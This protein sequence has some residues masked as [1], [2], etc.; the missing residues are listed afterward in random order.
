MAHRNILAISL[1]AARQRRKETPEHI[2]T[3]S[4]QVIDKTSLPAT[5]DTI[6]FMGKVLASVLGFFTVL[7]RSTVAARECER[8]YRLGDDELAN[9]GL[10]REDIPSHVVSKY[11]TV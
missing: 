5:T 3:N 11:L 2:M 6:A 10:E 4:Q 1:V 8:L 7:S 9:Q